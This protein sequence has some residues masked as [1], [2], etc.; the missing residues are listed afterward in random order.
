MQQLQGTGDGLTE[1]FW[2]GAPS[3]ALQNEAQEPNPKERGVSCRV[4]GL[5]YPDAA[6]AMLESLEKD[7]CIFEVN[8]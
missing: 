6:P 1:S 4:H 7:Q 5:T 3:R 8:F 2:D